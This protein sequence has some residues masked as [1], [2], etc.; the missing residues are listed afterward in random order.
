MDSSE[1]KLLDKLQCKN[2]FLSRSKFLSHRS[3]DS[4]QDKI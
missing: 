1:Y 4:R 2:E 3:C